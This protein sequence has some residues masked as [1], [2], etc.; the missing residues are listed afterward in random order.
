MNNEYAETDMQKADMLN[1]YF[2]SQMDLDDN[3][4]PLPHIPPTEYTLTSIVITVEDIKNVLR[5][6]NI[7][8]ACGPD[9]ISPHLL[10]E[11]STIIA[12]PLSIVFNRS[13]GQGYFP[14]CW[15][16]GNVTPIYKK[17]DKS[18]PSNY[19]P[20]TLLSSIG[21]V[22]ERC[23]H[24]YL[25]N[26][27]IDHQILTPFQS[28]FISGDSTTNQL[29]H[30][31]HTFC[32]AVDCG[33]E[34]RAVFCDISKAFDRVWHRGL[35]HKLAGIGCSEMITRWFS[36]YLTGR[37]QRIVINGQ[38]SEWLSVLAG[39]PQGSILGPLLFLI[40]INDIVKNLG[41]SIRLFAD[42]TSLYII[43]DS[44]DGAAYHLNVDLNS[45]STWADAW[46]VA[47]NTGK[48][49]SMI[50]SRKLHRPHHPPLLMNNTMLTETDTHRHLGL[51]L[52]NTCTWSEHIQTITT[53][54]WARLNLLRTLKFRVSRKSLE[55]MYISF[56]RPLLEYCDSVWDNA[57]TES[58][59]Q[60][61]AIHIEAARII[62]GATKLC[63]ISLLLSDL[64]W[65]SLLQNH[66]WSYT[67][68]SHW[69][70][71]SI[72]SGNH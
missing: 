16:Y 5:N 70:S 43:V 55:K 29:L 63:S 68:I 21:K 36:S 18:R 22:M 23:V 11:G 69:Y 15:K 44:P 67:H 2:A 25:Y 59:K 31:Y 1:K 30:T 57:T 7:N 34:V 24:K 41:C 66:P 35:I 9:L 6:L 56:V 53:K 17:N 61:D 38:V 60:L 64:G 47:F 50:F 27:I 19:R 49:L 32:N 12:L 3:N 39:V 46:L 40:Y 26:Y 28:G 58:K 45:I 52:S 71:P 10:K 37:K 48:T 72:D 20:I 33:K 62:T 13:L 14:T 51:T 42:D 4:R 8:K 65:E 54:A